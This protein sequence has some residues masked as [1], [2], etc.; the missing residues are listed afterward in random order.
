ME[1]GTSNAPM[2]LGI[3]GAVVSLPNLLC[4]SMCG[5]L[6]GGA[7]GGE[8][9]AALG[10]WL[11]FIPVVLGFVASFFGKSKPTFCGISMLICTLISFITVIMTGFTS[12]FGWAALILFLIAGI[13]AFTQTKEKV[14]A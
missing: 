12:I 13:I 3:I 4:A 8:A 14:S 2:I 1:R 6:V 5:A 9:G 10:A 7:A 11:G